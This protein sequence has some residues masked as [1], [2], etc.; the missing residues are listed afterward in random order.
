MHGDR[1]ATRVAVDQASGDAQPM[2]PFEVRI[3][4]EH[5]LG[6]VRRVDPTTFGDVELAEAQRSV[7]QPLADPF[8]LRREVGQSFGPGADRRARSP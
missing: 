3:D 6:A 1:G 5:P 2:G 8:D 4:T 7:E